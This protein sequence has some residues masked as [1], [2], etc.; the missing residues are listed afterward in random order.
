MTIFPHP[1]LRQLFEALRQE[2]LPQEELAH[3]LQVSTRTVRSDVTLLNEIITPHGAHFTHQR[4]EGYQLT[5]YH[6]QLFSA[7]LASLSE[8]RTPP[9]TSRERIV[10]LMILLL[11][12]EIPI[13]LDELADTW[14]LSR[15][16]LQGDMSEV[17]ERLAQFD[18]SVESKAHQGLRIQGRE[19]AIRGC[20]TQLL[21]Q[22]QQL[23]QPVQALLD[24]LC[25]SRTLAVI[26][27]Q[28]Q[29][30]LSEAPLRFSDDSR[31]QLSLYCA[32]LLSRLAAGRQQAPF[33][34]PDLA[35]AALILAGQILARLPTLTPPGAGEVTLLAIELQGRCSLPPDQLSPAQAQECQALI[36][37]LLNH[38]YQHYAYDLRADQPLRRDLQAHIN[39]MLLRVK[40]KITCYNPLTDHIKQHYPLAY[41]ITLSAIAD[42]SRQH[43]QQVTD[44][45]IGYL[46]IHIGVGLERNYD[47]GYRRPPH[48]LLVCDGANAT[49]RLLEARIR[50]DYPQLQLSVLTSVRE[51]QALS[52]IQAD[53]V[54]SHVRLEDKGLPLLQVNPFPT[55]FQLEQLGKLVLVDRTRPY[56]LDKYFSRRHF[57]LADQ[58]LT[59]EAL[60]SRLC[61]QLEEEEIVPA[62][63]HASLTEREQIVPTLLGEGFATPHSLRLLAHRTCVYTVLAP[64]GIE[65][66]NGE[67]V[68]VI[69]LL[70]ISKADYEEAM[71]LYE[72]FLALMSE[73]ASKALLACRDFSAFRQAARIHLD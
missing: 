18:L 17:R 48:A 36:E 33:D 39:P 71:G 47:I 58:P 66:G 13:K 14:Y 54:I 12:S 11:G 16:A 10:H 25:P 26:R 34:C 21:A 63:F 3:R 30:L 28:L 72:L 65:W 59:Q 57:W 61:Q 31:Q 8:E 52:D 22:E 45:E 67:K 46:V 44:H 56:L 19:Q 51:Y 27:T 38:I 15:N 20:L 50:R 7:L 55:P 23:G 53:F 70:A 42:W 64:E 29:E 62:S 49:S 1:R 60:F 5:I 69:F 37:H 4:G 41:D 6:P 43:Q 2:T 9:R 35:P 40:Y 68:Q 32:V 24:L 73:K